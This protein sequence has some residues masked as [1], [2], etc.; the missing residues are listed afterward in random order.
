M[1][2]KSDS[3]WSRFFDTLLVF[4]DFNFHIHTWDDD[5]VF[6]GVS[7]EVIYYD[8]PEEPVDWTKLESDMVIREANAILNNE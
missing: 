1:E 2:S 6:E 3:L 4:P 8:E 5:T 7:D